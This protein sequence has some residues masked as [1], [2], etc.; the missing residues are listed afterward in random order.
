MAGT[1]APF[2]ARA[3]ERRRMVEQQLAARGIDDPRLL[4]AFRQV[5]R[6][7]FV[8]PDYQQLAYA[9]G[10][11][12]IEAGQT[13]SQPWI[14]AEMI[15][16]AHI[17]GGDRVLEI[18]CGSGYAA[19]VMSRVA[20]RVFT[21]DR[22]QELVDVATTR[23]ATLGYDNIEARVGDGTLGWPEAAPF[24]AVLVAAAGPA[25]PP[26][27]KAQL[28]IGG[29]LV[30]PVGG[31]DDVQELIRLTRRAEDAF[32]REALAPVRFVPLIGEQGWRR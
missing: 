15:A 25:P 2:D 12:P 13:I 11:L 23:F 10:P 9:D 28:A 7:L 21:I 27:L 17:E 18:G 32:D 29:R 20:R 6:E 31:P 14:V 8:A 16:A 19:A 4:D 3:A 1:D 26:A 24:D 30:M 5:P 22:H